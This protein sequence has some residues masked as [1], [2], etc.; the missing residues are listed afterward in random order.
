MDNR[1]DMK[2]GP[3][4]FSLWLFAYSLS[5]WPRHDVDFIKHPYCRLS[6]AIANLRTCGVGRGNVVLVLMPTA[7]S[8]GCSLLF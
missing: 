1:W 8:G 7:S 3:L 6:V 4:G 2:R 5:I